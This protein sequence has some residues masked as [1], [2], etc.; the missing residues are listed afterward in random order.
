MAPSSDLT[1]QADVQRGRQGR[2]VGKRNC[3]TNPLHRAYDNAGHLKETKSNKIQCRMLPPDLYARLTALC[4]VRLPEAFIF[5]G[6]RGVP[7][8]PVYLT[9]L[10]KTAARKAEIHVPLYVGT[11]H[12][13]AH[14]V[15]TV[16]NLSPE[17]NKPS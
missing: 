8:R 2:G 16:P 7:Y 17:D 13:F 15:R 4:R 1:G 10:W 3:E 11:R 14:Y 6:K 5:S 9:Q 12:S